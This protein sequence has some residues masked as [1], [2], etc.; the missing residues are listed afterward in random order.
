MITVQKKY[1]NMYQV[2]MNDLALPFIK[3]GNDMLNSAPKYNNRLNRSTTYQSTVWRHV[4]IA[5]D[6]IEV[7]A[8]SAGLAHELSPHPGQDV[9]NAV[10]FHPQVRVVRPDDHVTSGLSDFQVITESD[11]QADLY[12]VHS[13][14]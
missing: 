13:D 14:D 4:I 11:R 1:H 8:Q 3:N 10:K 6:V 7:A 12:V 2:C 5:G 9:L